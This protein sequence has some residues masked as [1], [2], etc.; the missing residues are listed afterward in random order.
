M[1]NTIL[2]KNVLLDTL[3]KDVLIRGKRFEKI[4][5]AGTLNEADQVIDG[6]NS[7]ILPPFYNTHTHAAMTLLR[8]YGSDVPLKS[9]L[10]DFVWPR[11]NSLTPADIERGSRIAIRE[12]IKSGTVFFCDMYF[13]IE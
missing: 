10:E 3:R 9:W 2:I 5:P 13:N 8:G 11:E 7:A 6:Q 1:A 12:M 4:A